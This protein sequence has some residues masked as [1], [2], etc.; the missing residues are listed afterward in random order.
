MSLEDCFK[1]PQKASSTYEFEP[2]RIGKE[3]IK[4]EYRAKSIL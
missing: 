2:A 1:G 3:A 4:P